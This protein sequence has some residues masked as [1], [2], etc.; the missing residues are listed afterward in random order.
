MG[1]ITG[2]ITTP[3]GALY[4]AAKAG[5]CRFIESVNIELEAYGSK[6][7][8]LCVAPGFIDGTKFYDQSAANDLTKTSSIAEEIIGH[9]KNHDT[10]YIPFYNETYKNVIERYH[11]DPHEFGL[12]SYEYKKNTGR[13]RNESKI[14]IGYMSG[15]FDLFHIGHLNLIRRA[16]AQC[17]YLVVG[18]HASGARKGKE[19]FIPLDERK[20]MV[21]SCKYVDKVIDAPA[22]DSDAW[23]EW[24]YKKLFV[25][26]DY[27]GSERFNRYEEIFRDTDVEI[28]YFPYTKNT[29]STQ[30]RKAI[31]AIIN[32]NSRQ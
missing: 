32:E 29:S 10:L 15:T 1:S 12:S 23:P 20:T 16:K 30:I 28:V 25:G 8:I 9:L 13:I 31:N 18:V 2:L 3:S 4:S 24:H 22:E 5:I 26:S 11:K 14:V 17:D 27:K 19:T 6:N 7:R 21:A